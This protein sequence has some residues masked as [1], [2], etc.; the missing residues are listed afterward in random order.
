MSWIVS[1]PCTRDEAE[2]LSGEVPELDALPEAPVIVTREIDED[3]GL[4]QLDA[5]LDDKPGAALLGLLQ[6]LIPSAKGRKPQVEELVEQDWVTLSQQGLEPVQAG[7]FFVHTS[8]YADRVPAGTVP[9]LIDASQAFGTGG[10]DTTAGCL[11]ML[12][13]LARQGASPRNIADIGTGTG[14][15]AFAAMHLWPRAKAIASDIDPAS[16]VVTRDNAAI[17]G[18]PLGRSGGRL[19]LAVAPGTDHPAIRRRAPYDLVI[20]NILAGPLITLAPDIG[21]ATSPGGHAILAG[22]IARQMEPVLAA[23]RAQGFRLA[24]RGGSAEWPCLLLVKRR[25]YGYRRKQRAFH[26]SNPAD[27]TFGSW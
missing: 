22:L 27:A 23:Y 16:I 12:D 11:A 15:L 4:W 8:S 13:R 17:N 20:A 6:A 24:A 1:L 14:L 26:R 2:A 21:A 18:V 10:H 5:Y 19:A 25:R 3:L 9:F 7:R